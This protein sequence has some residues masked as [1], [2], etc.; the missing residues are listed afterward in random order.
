MRLIRRSLAVPLAELADVGSRAW[1]GRSDQ[2]AIF[3]YHGV[4]ER[5]LLPFCWHQLS[6]K[7]FERQLRWIKRYM[8]PLPLEEAL[9]RLAQNTLPPRAC[10]VTFDDGYRS[11]RDLAFPLLRELAVPATV[12]LITDLVGT[13]EVPWPDR[14]YLAVRSSRAGELDGSRLG[15]GR[16][17]LTTP[18]ARR[19]ALAQTLDALKSCAVPEKNQILEQ[20][21]GA[22]GAADAPEP[23]EFQMLDWEDVRALGAS[24]LVGFGAH[25]TRHEILSQ[26]TDADVASSIRNSHELLSRRLPQVPRVFAYPNGRAQDFDARA[27]AALRG[28]H[29]PFALSTVQGLARQESDA[30]ALPRINVGSDL[31]FALFRLRARGIALGR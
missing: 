19:R 14:L 21:L 28:L 11:V 27:Q 18:H 25:T 24:G 3:M 6:L 20:W 26:L 4:V 8:A 22:L 15:L 29:V 17:P 30:L 9:D 2:L 5:P 7:A 16:M 1:P 23:A 13:H 12:F 10:A 31:P